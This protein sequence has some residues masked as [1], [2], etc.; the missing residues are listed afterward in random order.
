MLKPTAHAENSR[1]RCSLNGLIIF[2]QDIVRYLFILI[3]R[4]VSRLLIYICFKLRKMFRNL[5]F[6]SY[7]SLAQ[8]T[9]YTTR[10]QTDICKIRIKNSCRA[11]SGRNIYLHVYSILKFI[12]SAANTIETIDNSFI[13][14]FIDGPEVSLKG[15]PTVS[16]TTA[17]LC[18]S[19]PLPP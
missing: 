17:A 14:I 3:A 19:L 8:K 9:W 13:R 11:K 2:L 7:Y 18:C 10:S 12:T 1:M 5:L 16:P 4:S 15:S 6:F